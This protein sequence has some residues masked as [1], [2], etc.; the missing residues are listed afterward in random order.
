[1]SGFDISTFPLHYPSVNFIRDRCLNYCQFRQLLK[2]LDNEFTDAPFYTEVRWLSCHKVLK[3]FYLLRQEI[4]MFLE[5]KF[6]STDELKDESW[7]QDLAFAV[8]ITAHLNDLNLKLRGKNKLIIALYD[9]VK[10]F[11]LKL[12]LWKSQVSRENLVHFTTCKELQN[13]ADTKSALSFAKYDTHPKSLSKEFEKRFSYFASYE[14][15]FALFSGPFSFDV[16]EVEENLQMELLE[17]QWIP[18]SD[19]NIWKW[20]YLIS[21]HTFRK[22]LETLESLPQGSWHCSAPHICGNSYFL[23]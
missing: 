4:I 3:R 16:A 18:H 11:F 13:S 17:I 19:Q 1:M 22:G 7:L 8:D 10:C 9:D 20:E 14:R 12:K 2:D 6:R 15:Q 5:M 23:S 21:F